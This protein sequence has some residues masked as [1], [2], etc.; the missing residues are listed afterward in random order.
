MNERNGG[1]SAGFTCYHLNK[2]YLAGES[3]IA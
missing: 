2:G 1:T 3:L